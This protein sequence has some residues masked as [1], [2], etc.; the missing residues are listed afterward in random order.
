[1]I[2][3]LLGLFS[4]DLG[5]DL[6]TANTLVCA[7]G[8]GII[9]SEP[10]VVAVYA[11]TNRVVSNGK[12]EAV[13][14]YAKQMLGKAPASIQVIRPMR[15]GVIADFEI[16]EAMLG[17]FIRK[18]HGRRR[19]NRPRV[20]VA[21]PSGITTVEKR[22]V[23]NSAER[24]GAREVRLIKEPMAAA[25]GVGLPVSEPRGS[26]IVDIGGGTSEIA[27]ISLGDIVES[28]SLKVAGDEL[29]GA[30]QRYLKE[31]YNLEIS[32]RAA[33]QIKIEIGSAYRLDEELSTEVRGKDSIASLP[34]SVVVRSEEIRGA[35][36]PS[37]EQIVRGIKSTL[38]RT[39]ADLSADLMETGITLAGGGA[40]LRG[41]DR[42]IARD[43]GLP[44]RRADDPL[45]AVA[46]GTGLVLDNIDHHWNILEN[47]H[48]AL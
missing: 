41:I 28:T 19:F 5:I 14:E 39:Q 13:G 11:G 43:T 38:D 34:R 26:M 48:D 9:L 1:M 47:G 7:R 6:G 23:I 12:G 45:T 36:M 2:H 30:I 16:T 20:L 44:V 10:S 27:V 33:E 29:D 31:A 4:K 40:L 17:Y 15:E 25:I 8:E 46:R 32:E 35:L 42:M 37:L 24:A 18:A 22:A 21:V 3:L